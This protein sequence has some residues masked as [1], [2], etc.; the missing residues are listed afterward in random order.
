[1]AETTIVDEVK[2]ASIEIADNS[3]QPAEYW[4]VISDAGSRRYADQTA[5]FSEHGLPVDP[6]FEEDYRFIGGGLGRF[7]DGDRRKARGDLP[8]REDMIRHI[9]ANFDEIMILLH[10]FRTEYCIANDLKLHGSI[11]KQ[12]AAQ[13]LNTISTLPYYLNARTHKP[14][15]NGQ[16]PD[17]V[18]GL[19]AGLIGIG[20]A[21]LETNEP[22]RVHRASSMQKYLEANP[23]IFRSDTSGKVNAFIRSDLPPTVCPATS[24][25]I[26]DISGAFLVGQK[27]EID[28]RA[29]LDQ[30]GFGLEEIPNLIGYDASQKPLQDARMGLAIVIGSADKSRANLEEAIELYHGVLANNQSAILSS[31]GR[32]KGGPIDKPKDVYLD[33]AKAELGKLSKKSKKPGRAAGSRAAGKRSRGRS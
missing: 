33:I 16:I 10:A 12:D 9:S 19:R 21:L 2:P 26:S 22:G 11:N 27:I 8:Y 15:I 30:I 3:D 31:L 23:S 18:V 6:L 28:T 1:M 25:M 14:F 7:S 5:L 24:Q 17:T 20:G 4:M 13:I 29:V 32:S